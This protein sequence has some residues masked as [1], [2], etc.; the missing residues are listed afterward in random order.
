MTRY[1]D[2][3]KEFNVLHETLTEKQDDYFSVE[4]IAEEDDLR[5]RPYLNENILRDKYPNL[6]SVL[7]HKV[8]QCLANCIRAITPIKENPGRKLAREKRLFN[9]DLAKARVIVGKR[10]GR[11]QKLSNITK[12]TYHRKEHYYIYYQICIL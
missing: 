11:I 1:I 5:E 9:Q 8:Y 4:P 3:L 10:F 6:R 2:I 12:D 7:V